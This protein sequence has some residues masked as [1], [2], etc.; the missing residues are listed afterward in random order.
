MRGEER[1]INKS[2]TASGAT[3]IGDFEDRRGWAVAGWGGSKEQK[4]ECYGCPDTCRFKSDFP[5]WKKIE[6]MG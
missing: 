5:I 3:L 4:S 2:E 6:E 1:Q